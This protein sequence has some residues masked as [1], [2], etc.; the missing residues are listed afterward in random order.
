[1]AKEEQEQGCLGKNPEAEL[2]ELRR[3]VKKLRRQM[4]NFQDIVERNKSAEQTRANIHEKL[5]EEKKRQENLLHLLLKHSPDNILILDQ[6]K[7]FAYCAECFLKAA[8]IPNFGML[9]GCSFMEVFEPFA[10]VALIEQFQA[11]FN[12]VIKDKRDGELDATLDIGNRGTPRTYSI[13]LTSMLGESGNLDGYI[14]L[15]HDSTDILQAKREAELASTAKSEFLANMSHEIR[16][17]MNA[18]IGMT[19]IGQSTSDGG[20]KDYCLGRIEKASNHLLGV[21][22]DILDMSKIEAN[23]LELIPSEFNFEEMVIKAINVAAFRVG[24]KRQNL[25]I[26]L[27]PDLPAFL[28]ADEQRLS[29]VIT[30]LL[31]NAVKFTHEGGDIAFRAEKIEDG[32]STCTIR[33]EVKDAGIGI[34][35]EQQQKLF[36]SF[37]QADGGISRRFGGTGLGLAISKRII[38]LMEGNIWVE[39]ELGKG[40]RFIFTITVEK[41]AT[42]RHESVLQTSDGT[43]LRL[44]VIDGDETVRNFFSRTSEILK[45]YHE[46]VASIQEAEILMEKADQDPF[47]ILFMEW[48][49]VEAGDFAVVKKIK[50]QMNPPVI[51]AIF[52]AESHVFQDEAKKRGVDDFLSKP[53]FVSSIVDCMTQHFGHVHKDAAGKALADYTGLFKNSRI[54]LAEDVAINREI[55]LSLLESTELTIVCAENGD[56]ACTL[57]AADPLSYDIIFMDIQMPGKNGYEATYQIRNMDVPWARNIPIV[58]MTANV[59]TE[60]I[61]K[62][63]SV[64]MN[65][66]IGKPLR[67]DSLIQCLQKYLPKRK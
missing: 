18:I 58:A 65:D 36:H 11:L 50:Q 49:L 46:T 8:R 45:L 17:P 25:S 43:P 21:I 35:K 12:S 28:I 47:H 44:L 62:C 27:D 61:E 24:E 16:T 57:F 1:M 14:L 7:C 13:H 48:A 31:S 33:V 54:L 37:V 59:F 20:K 52:A 60:D 51:I 66:H 5:A 55:V 64:G 42:L 53:L 23:K 34:S 2:N 15:F 6:N 3:E 39:S 40:S 19:S 4:N 67:F 32:D 56:E 26:F 41:G 30:N 63:H 22:N 29:Q 38:D 10:S 9:R